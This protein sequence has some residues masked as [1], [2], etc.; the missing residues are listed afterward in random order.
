MV[1]IHNLPIK[2]DFYHKPK[3]ENLCFIL[4]NNLIKSYKEESEEINQT[5]KDLFI[6]ICKEFS[7]NNVSNRKENYFINNSNYPNKSSSQVNENKNI[8]IYNKDIFLTEAKKYFYVSDIYTNI[9]EETNIINF[10]YPIKKNK[11]EKVGKKEEKSNSLI[12][13]YTSL[14]LLIKFPPV[15]ILLFFSW[16]I[17]KYKKRMI[18]II[19]FI[20]ILVIIFSFLY[21]IYFWR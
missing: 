18:F 11:K 20:I 13:Y 6:N 10:V 5:E 15:G 21:Y 8:K 9:E 16:M 17:K 4:N 12:M 3:Y 19:I 14:I 7:I 2:P 1:D